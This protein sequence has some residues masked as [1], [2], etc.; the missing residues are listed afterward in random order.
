MAAVGLISAG[1][2]NASVTSGSGGVSA[3]WFGAEHVTV[4]TSTNWGGW[5]DG[6][7]PDSYQAVGVCNNGTVRYGTVRWA[8]DRR[9]SFVYCSSGFAGRYFAKIYA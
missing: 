1:P 9:G 5:V 8:G 4:S 7:G 6:N 2:A 3:E